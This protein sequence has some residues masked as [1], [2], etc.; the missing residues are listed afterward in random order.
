MCM[1]KLRE[2][3]IQMDI[4]R[5]RQ[6]DGKNSHTEKDRQ[7]GLSQ[8]DRKTNKRIGKQIDKQRIIKGSI[9]TKKEVSKER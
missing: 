5:H 9:D 8:V 3:K 6:I 4:G 7:T 1:C 2:V